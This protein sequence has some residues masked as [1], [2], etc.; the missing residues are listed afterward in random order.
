MLRFKMVAQG[1]GADVHDE[2]KKGRGLKPPYRRRGGS[3]NAAPVEAALGRANIVV[4][5]VLAMKRTVIPATAMTMQ[6]VKT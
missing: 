4:V 3:A 1:W 5:V 6:S 2:S